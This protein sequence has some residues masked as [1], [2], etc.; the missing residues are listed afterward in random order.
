MQNSEAMNNSKNLIS[1]VQREKA[2][3]NKRINLFRIIAS[4]FALFILTSLLL[5]DESRKLSNYLVSYA[6]TLVILV[7]AVVFYFI[8]KK[9]ETTG[10]KYPVLLGYLIIIVDAL[11]ITSVIYTYEGA[12]MLK[13]QAFN[14]YYV[15][16]CLTVYS[17]SKRFTLF[18][19]LFSSFLYLVFFLYVYFDNQII[20]GTL[21]NEYTSNKI[22]PIS[23]FIKITLFLLCTFILGSISGKYNNVIQQYINQF[24]NASEERRRY[25]RTKNI[26]ETYVSKEVASKALAEGISLRGD[27]K[28]ATIMFCDIRNFT[29]I[30]QNMSPEET[31]TF[32][33]LSLPIMARIIQKNKGIVDKFTGDGLMAIFGLPNGDKED[34]LMAIKSAMQILTIMNHKNRRLEQ[35]KIELG[36]GIHTG[37]VIAGNIGT[38]QRMNYTVVGPNVNLASRLEGLTKKYQVNIFISDA[39][40]KLVKDS[41]MAKEFG[42]VE[43]KGFSKPIKIYSV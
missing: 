6:M 40:Y 25:Q 20:L 32:L 10:K 17:Y 43:V 12:Q 13:T 7:S 28:E 19:G 23:V 42:A 33:N 30:T 35:Y 3:G 29:S 11:I 36:F 38:R 37:D 2:R 5:V 22:S 39:T 14:L 1:L 26:F 21:L 4:I 34:P 8:Y 24:K 31:V 15:L 18:T 41:L 27:R 9:S 16:L